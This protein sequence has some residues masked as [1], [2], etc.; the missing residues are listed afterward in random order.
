M[1][2]ASICPSVCVSG[3]CLDDISLTAQPYGTKLV[4][5]MYYQEVEYH[6]ENWFAVD[7]SRSQQGLL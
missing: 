3:F 4:M 6:V 1:F 7:L 2:S 5:V